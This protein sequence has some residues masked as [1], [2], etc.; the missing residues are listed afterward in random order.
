MT[1]KHLLSITLLATAT[2]THATLCIGRFARDEL[3]K[4]GVQ[5]FKRGLARAA[6]EEGNFMTVQF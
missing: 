1:T 2:L 5:A 3:Q 6:L 4:L